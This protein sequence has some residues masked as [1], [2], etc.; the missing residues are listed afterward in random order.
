MKQASKPLPDSADL[1]GSIARIESKIKDVQIQ[2][3]AAEAASTSSKTVKDRDYLRTEELQLRTEEQQLKTEEQQLRTKEQ[4]LRDQ[5]RRKEEGL[6]G[7]ESRSTCIFG[8]KQQVRG[9]MR[10][11]VGR[12]RPKSV[13]MH[14][15]LEV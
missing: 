10:I 4:Q 14:A 15:L 7:G 5:L 1:E 3:Q 2:I 13:C 11:Y 8:Y 6:Q 9:Q 12:N